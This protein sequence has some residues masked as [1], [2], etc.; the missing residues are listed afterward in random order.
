[1]NLIKISTVPLTSSQVIQIYFRIVV[2][3][4]GSQWN[5]CAK[6]VINSWVYLCLYF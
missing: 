1:M 2:E 5:S 3:R 4:T 6:I